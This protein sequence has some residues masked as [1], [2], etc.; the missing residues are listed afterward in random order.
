MQTIMTNMSGIGLISGRFLNRISATVCLLL[1]T[2]FVGCSVFSGC[3]SSGDKVSR[4]AFVNPPLEARPGAYWCWLNG[5]VDH[6]QMTREM[7]EAKALGMRGF[8]IWDVGVIRPVGMVPQGPAFLGEESLKTIEHAMKEADRLGLELNMIAA[9]SWNAGGSWVEKSDG[10]K[11]IASSSVDV[12][13]P[14]KFDDVLPVPCDSDTYYCDISVLAVGCSIIRKIEPVS[15][16][17]HSSLT[18]AACTISISELRK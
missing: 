18:S 4:A 6:Q 5:V 15:W 13:G 11:R 3:S 16:R 9:S 14:A 12:T 17:F 2:M 10:S 7:E 8:E 1:L